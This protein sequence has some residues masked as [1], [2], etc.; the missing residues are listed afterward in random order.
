MPVDFFTKAES[1]DDHLAKNA[2]PG[3]IDLVISP[4]DQTLVAVAQI[5]GVHVCS[6]CHR[7]FEDDVFSP[8][9]SVEFNPGGHGTRILIHSGCVSKVKGY[10]GNLLHDME[11]GHQALRFEAHATKP[12]AADER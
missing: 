8:K 10:R 1:K 7:E 9:R 6:Y 5:Q 3:D 11:R 2:A 12:F 4:R